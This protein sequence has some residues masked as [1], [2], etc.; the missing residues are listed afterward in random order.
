VALGGLAQAFVRLRIDSSQVAADTNKGIE[1]GAAG[2][3]AEKA[4][5]TTGERFSAGFNKAFKAAAIGALVIAAVGAASIKMGVDFQSAMTKIQTQAG[6]SAADVKQL[7]AAVL[8][9][10]PSTQQG[11]LQLADA[12]FHLKSV[13]LDNVDAMKALKVAS[14]LAAVGGSNLEDTTNAIAAAW[15][16]GISGAQNFGTAAATVN[17]IIGSGNMRMADFVSAMGTGVLSAATTF[18]VSLK[19]VGGALALMTDE[20]V[21]AVDAATRLKMSFS[22]LGAPSKAAAAQ[23][24]TIGLTGLQLANTMRGPTGLVGTI[25]LL[26]SHLDAAGLSASQQAILLSHAFGGGRSSSAILTMINNLDTLRKKQDQIT[27]GM[28]KYGP[29][30]AAQRQT[31]QAQLDILRSSVETIGVRM[32]TALLGPAVK[33]VH[34]ISGSLIP[35]ILKI[36]GVLGGVL[37]NP[38][39]GAFLGGLVAAAVAIAGIVKL[40]KIWKGI[41]T[42][43]S[44]EEGLAAMLGPVGL[45]IVAVA[46]LAAGIAI[47][48]ERSSTFRK[49]VEGAFRAVKGAA[50]DVWDWLKGHWKLLAA[51]LLAPFAPLIAAGYALYKLIGIVAHVFDSIKS[52]ITGGFDSWWKGHGKELE[53][54]W[55]EAWSNIK[56]VF[57]LLFGPIIQAVRTGWALITTVISGGVKVVEDLVRIAWGWI[58]ATTRGTWDLI[59]GIL[60][61][62]WAVI[63]G[64]VKIGIAGV[65]SV[66]KIAWD[67]IVGIFNVALDLLTGKWGKAWDDIKT[68]VTQVWNAIKGFLTSAWNDIKQTAAAAWNA[69][70]GGVKS[71]ASDL[72]GYV[73]RIPGMI[74]QALGDVGHLLWN[75]GVNIIKGLVGGITSMVGS[76]IHTVASIG[77]DIINAIGSPFG[78][79]FSEP[80]EATKMVKAGQNVMDGL[81]KGMKSRV[82]QLKSFLGGVAKTVTALAKESPAKIQVQLTTA[83]KDESATQNQVNQVTQI[84][85]SLKGDRTKEESQIKKLVADRAAEYKKDGAASKALRAEQEKQIKSLE[86]LRSAQESQIKTVDAALKPLK[87]ELSKLKTEVGKLTKAL[88]D[89]TKAAAKAAASSS[90]GSSSSSSS[91]TS[92]TDSSSASAT[93]NW[94]AFNQ[95]L[96]ATSGPLDVTGG[97]A[98]GWQTNPGPLGGFGLGLADVSGPSVAGRFGGLP[99]GSGDALITALNM[100]TGRLDDLIELTREQPGRTAAGLNAA[101]N[102]V[103][104]HAVVKGNW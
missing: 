68:T 28:S 78:I 65:E 86:K 44:G 85:N 39:G 5:E 27:A 31:V 89:A 97:A 101:M 94:G 76:A 4:G 72:I 6:G 21:P 3:D 49:I 41:T 2:S 45:T 66:I 42:L 60:K 43:L 24:K 35:G 7:S 23:L 98:A 59:S 84:I 62:A 29:A 93:P 79:H 16:S 15:R 20:G 88:A 77:H 100:Q 17:A 8:K 82:G 52:A 71:F 87:S 12:L 81:L 54:V 25:G 51:I 57:D 9:L 26:K 90:S 50:M 83:K 73:K 1:E 95:W 80:S 102:G 38:F 56:A 48:W 103:V 92:S 22:L 58:S 32:G 99:Q 14:D 69:L 34:F 75:A 47:L 70:I 96:G 30:V 18:G 67:V 74:L 33:F 63:S 91:D 11:P 53:Q 104:S 10:A 40:M 46:A 13:G 55:H 19:Q 61:S 37:K 36:G 64:V